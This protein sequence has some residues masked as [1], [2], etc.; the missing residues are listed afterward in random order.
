MT[1]LQSLATIKEHTFTSSLP[2]VARLRTAW[3]NVAARWYV[4]A[5]FDQQQAFNQ[6]VAHILDEQEERIVAQDR[7]LVALTHKVA[8]MQRKIDAE[9][10]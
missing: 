7:E 4:A 5:M 8:Q 9:Q 2:L 6:A 10:A 3:L 1:E